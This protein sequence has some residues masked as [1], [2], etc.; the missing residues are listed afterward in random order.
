MVRR[1]QK[2]SPP[3]CRETGLDHARRLKRHMPPAAT[4]SRKGVSKFRAFTRTELAQ[5]RDGGRRVGCPLLFERLSRR[6]RDERGEFFLFGRV[7]RRVGVNVRF[8]KVL[9]TGF[10]Q[11]IL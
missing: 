9:F 2:N 10:G 7:K 8:R 6:H 5:G 11:L 1:R 3:R 4:D